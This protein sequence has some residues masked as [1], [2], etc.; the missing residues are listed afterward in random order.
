MLLS[1]IVL[2]YLR[3]AIDKKIGD[4][5]NQLDNRIIKLESDLQGIDKRMSNIESSVQKI[6]EIT[7]KFVDCSE[8]YPGLKS[9]GLRSLR[10]NFIIWD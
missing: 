1:K 7:E 2:M 4:K 5:F 8:Q 9:Q 10:K 3:S 6:P